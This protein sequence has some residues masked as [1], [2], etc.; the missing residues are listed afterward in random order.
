MTLNPPPSQQTPQSPRRIPN[1]RVLIVGNYCHDVLIQNGSVV[2]ETLGG[3]ASFISNVLDSSSVS[4]ELVSK[5]GHDFRYE[6]I[7]SPIVAPDKETTIFEA[8]FDLGIDGIG[9]ADR[10]LKRVSACDPILPSDI[11]DSRFDFGMAVGV[12]V[13]VTNG[14]KGLDA[15]KSVRVKDEVQKRKKQ[16]NLSSS[17][18]NDHNEFHERLSPARFSCVDSQ[19]QPKLLVNGHSCDR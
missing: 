3:A 12:G 17:H 11:P 13:V 16:C 5:V 6:V 10:V 2:A 14:E 9:H 1:R 4:C 8:Y 18:K 19:L 15:G 7:H